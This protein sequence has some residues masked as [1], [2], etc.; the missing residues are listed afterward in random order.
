MIKRAIMER[1]S[2]CKDLG[3][4]AAELGISVNALRIRAHRLGYRN[5]RKYE[6]K[7]SCPNRLQRVR[8]ARQLRKDGYSVVFIAGVLDVTVQSIYSYLKVK[9]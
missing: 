4:L 1:Y 2:D 8:K 7:G 6:K 3:A 5:K 9:K